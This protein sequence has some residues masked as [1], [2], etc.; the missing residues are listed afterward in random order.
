MSDE[1]LAGPDLV[2]TID[3]H[4]PLAPPCLSVLNDACARIAVDPAVRVTVLRASSD[5]WT[6]WSEEAWSNAADLG[7]IGDPFG[8]FAALPQP[9]SAVMEGAV[10]DAGL[11]LA[12][13]ADIRIADAATTFAMPAIGQGRLPIAGGLQRLARTVGRAHALDL[14]LRGAAVDAATARR[15]GLISQIVEHD[16]GFQAATDLA[17]QIAGRG[18]VA[19]RAAKEAV[20]RGLDMPLEE[21]LRF[22]TDL[23]VLLQTTADRAEGVKAFTEKRPPR[24]QGR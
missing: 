20:R 17:R 11:E 9:T 21:A 14:V 24:F 18:P 6:G 15:W 3:L 7:I 19:L 8:P 13:C 1:H 4:G 2:A 16:D 5:V 12:L 23:T 10:R 22:E